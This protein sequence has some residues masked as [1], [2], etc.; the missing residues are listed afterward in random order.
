MTCL[1]VWVTVTYTDHLK[2]LIKKQHLFRGRG[3]SMVL[4]ELHVVW[5]HLPLYTSKSTGQFPGKLSGS[6]EHSSNYFFLH[7]WKHWHIY[8]NHF[9]SNVGLLS[10]GTSIILIGSR[11]CCYVRNK[12]FRANQRPREGQEWPLALAKYVSISK[13][14]YWTRGKAPR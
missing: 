8:E 6:K 2:R 3:S 5:R 12:I 13:S 1:I 7:K 10:L 9:P 4:N 11:G 14:R